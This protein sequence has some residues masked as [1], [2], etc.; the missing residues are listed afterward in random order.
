MW[1][2]DAYDDTIVAFRFPSF[3]HENFPALTSF[4]NCTFSNPLHLSNTWQPRRLIPRWNTFALVIFPNRDASPARIFLLHVSFQTVI[5]LS[6][7]L[8]SHLS[9]VVHILMKNSLKL[10]KQRGKD[11]G[12]KTDTDTETKKNIQTD[13]QKESDCNFSSQLLFVSKSFR[14]FVPG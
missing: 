12:R 11:R 7:K 6:C 1:V 2:H 13:R 5:A 8:G 10:R 14:H 3:L 4:F 9:F